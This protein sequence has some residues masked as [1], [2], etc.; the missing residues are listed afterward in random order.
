MDVAEGRFA[1]NAR[2]AIIIGDRHPDLRA[3]ANMLAG[4]LD[5]NVERAVWESPPNG[6]GTS[7]AILLNLTESD[8]LGREGYRLQVATDSITLSANQP[9]GLFYGVQTLRQ[10]LEASDTENFSVRCLRIT[11]FPRYP[12]R[13]FFLDSGRQFHSVAFIKR[14]IDLLAM[15]K[16]N[17][18][19]WRLTDEAGWRIHINAYP[20]LTD[21]GSDVGPW[22]GQSGYYTQEQLKDIVEY[23][24]RRYVTVVPEID[25]PGHSRAALI[26]YP[27][28]SCRQTAPSPPQGSSADIFCGGR[29]STYR[30]LESV[31]DEICVV[32]PSEFIHIGGDD[33]PKDRWVECPECRKKR[34]QLGLKNMNEL[35]LWMTNRLA[36]Y[37]NQKGRRAICWGDLVGSPGLQLDADIIVQWWNYR[38]MND[39]RLREALDRGHDV[40]LSPNYYTHLNYPVVPWSGYKQ[41]R[42]FDL[43]KAYAKNPVEQ[44][45]WVPVPHRS[46]LLGIE[47]CLWS[48]YNVTEE[49]VDARVFPRILALCELMW[50]PGERMPFDRFRSSVAE[51]A[52]RLDKIGVRIGP[53]MKNEAATDDYGPPVP[54]PR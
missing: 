10:L 33:A 16:L 40:I 32:F 50:Q 5:L 12:W 44:L 27:Q 21:I 45:S 13:G 38:Q 20:R 3:I 41:N 47:A 8:Q 1:V 2:T 29:E 30:F 34:R 43:E 51:H 17:V 11:D 25:L 37:L 28:V 49:M 35:Q 15:H 4:Y 9:Q 42:I 22:E 54:R 39:I 23:A 19:H 18:L 53:A 14:Y 6:P 48:D 31:L 24:G 46:R 36:A 26:A 52:K 7:G